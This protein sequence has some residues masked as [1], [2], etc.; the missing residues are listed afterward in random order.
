[1]RAF[2][3]QTQVRRAGTRC[4]ATY[5]VPVTSLSEAE[6]DAEQGH[7]TMQPKS[8]FGPA[9]PTFRVWW[10]TDGMLHM[11]RFYGFEQYG[12]AEIDE[13]AVGEPLPDGVKFVG[14]L[15]PVQ[16]EAHA[17]VMR[18]LEA[19]YNGGIVCLPCGY[20]KTVLAVKLVVDL[21]RRA[22]IVVHK[23]VLRDQW[24]QAFTVFA[25]ALRVRSLAGGGQRVEDIEESDVLIVMVLTL[26]RRESSAEFD[27]FGTVVCDEAHHIGARVMNQSLFNIRAKN[28][29]GLTATKDRTDGLTK[30]LHFSLGG[31]AFRAARNGGES[32]RVSVAVYPGISEIK[33]RDGRPV[34]AAM[35]N[36][37]A[38]NAERNEFIVNRVLAMYAAGRTIIVL[39]DRLKQLALFRKALT[40]PDRVPEDD[41]GMFQGSTRENERADQLRRRIVLCSFS[42]ASEG[43]DKREA[44]TLVLATPKA[45]VEQA[46]GRIQRP[47][48]HKKSPLVIDVSDDVGIFRM[49]RKKRETLYRLKYEFRSFATT[50]RRRSGLSKR[51]RARAR[52]G[53]SGGSSGVQRGKKKGG[54]G[55]EGG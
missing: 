2:L 10:I 18:H 48:E 36:K 38:S 24:M 19:N 25:P 30:L 46:V 47:S 3:T 43:L 51:A 29:I 9:P 53:S 27:S 12:P 11:P 31:E 5:S 26:A 39:S 22:V 28:V 6:L 33:G 55:R 45:K 13:R 37:I 16:V 7:L 14:A 44:D 23:A 34:V 41:V 1:M 17:G 32:V 4:G 49:L 8:S 40:Q 20:G 52:R 15:N 54:G 35:I 21:G 50:I 42:M